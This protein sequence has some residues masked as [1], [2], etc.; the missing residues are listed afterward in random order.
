M[1]TPLTGDAL[2]SCCAI[3]PPRSL[4]MRW[5]SL[6]IYVSH[7]GDPEVHLWHHWWEQRAGCQLFPCGV[8]RSRALRWVVYVMEPTDEHCSSSR[9]LMGRVWVSMTKEGLEL[10]EYK[11][12][13]EDGGE[14]GQVWEPLQT[15]EKRS[16]IRRWRRWQSP[17]GSCSS[18]CC[19][20]MSTTA[21]QPT[22]SASWKLRH[23]G[24]TWPW[25]KWWPKSTWRL[26]WPPPR[27]DPAAEGKRQA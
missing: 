27:G 15:H 26:P 10:P 4:E 21:G 18:P 13:E 6:R 19:S 3:T 14:Q 24:A 17:T 2:P 9:S 23:F 16:W 1:R 25:T 22:C 8:R 20:V 5:T 7:E 11:E 12:W